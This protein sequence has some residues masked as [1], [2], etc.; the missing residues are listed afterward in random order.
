MSEKTYKTPPDDFDPIVWVEENF[1]YLEACVLE[2]LEEA[3]G[4]DR[5]IE[6]MNRHDEVVKRNADG[7]DE[8]VEKVL[9]YIFEKESESWRV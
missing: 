9:D 5:A 1:T 8:D 2:E 7:G 4:T 3:V 6:W